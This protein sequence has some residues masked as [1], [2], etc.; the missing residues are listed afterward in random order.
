[1]DALVFDSAPLSC[2][3]RAG[4]LPLLERLT[5]GFTRVTT[6]AVLDELRDGAGEYPALR[7]AL[8]LPWLRIESLGSLEEMKLF[9]AYLQP[10]GAGKHN[11]GEATVLAWAEAHRAIAFTDD[12]LA[13]QIA[14]RR[15]VDVK[16]T[17]ALVARGVRQGLLQEAEAQVLID[18][19]LLADARF[20]CLGQAA[21]AARQ[22]DRVTHG[23]AS[24][25]QAVLSPAAR[26]VQEKSPVGGSEQSCR[27]LTRGKGATPQLSAPLAR[28]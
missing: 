23:G 11:I 16:R 5:E 7:A 8:E 22:T 25:G 26:S 14:R 10:L 6:Q 27:A 9:A 21:G 15:G 17:L 24:S 12:E 2:F 4:Q 20:P 13:V 1:M 18:E 19:L 28:T 3:A